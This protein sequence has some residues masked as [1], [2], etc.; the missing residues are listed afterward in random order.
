[1]CQEDISVKQKRPDYAYASPEQK[2]TITVLESD[3]AT[4]VVG[5]KD[6]DKN[7][8]PTPNQLINGT[9]K[10]SVSSFQQ[11]LDKPR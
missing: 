11:K 1:M 2:G 10:P 3:L 7:G 5:Q 8:E 4:T 9:F 6:M